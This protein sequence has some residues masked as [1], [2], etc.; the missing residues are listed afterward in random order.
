MTELISFQPTPPP[1]SPA[2]V[3]RP[4]RKKAGKKMRKAG[5]PKVP[6]NL[7]LVTDA[8]DREAS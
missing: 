5:E 7:R 6:K 4:P 1:V 3:Q 8:L 2:A